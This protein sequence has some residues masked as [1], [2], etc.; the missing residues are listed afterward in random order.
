MEDYSDDPSSI[1]AKLQSEIRRKVGKRYV[2]SVMLKDN[3]NDDQKI[4]IS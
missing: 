3:L 4:K 1:K 2:D